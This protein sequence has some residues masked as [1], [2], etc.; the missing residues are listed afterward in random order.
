MF[1][2]KETKHLNT[3]K[4]MKL[5][6]F[7]D[8]E[9][10]NQTGYPAIGLEYYAF[11]RGPVPKKFW[12]EIKDGVAPDDLKDKVVL[13]LKTGEY[14][15]N[16]KEIEFIA[17]PKAQVNFSIFTPREKKILEKLAFIYEDANAKMMS[18][19]SHEAEWPWEI[20]KNEKGINSEID[21][22][23]ALKKDSTI[24]RE[25]AEENLRDHFSILRVFDI[26]PVK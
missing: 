7:F 6:N 3:T 20:T 12:L 22:L 23:L 5:L 10:F 14:D 8:F 9:H 11:E 1:F 18:E 4:L 17:K 16:R 15:Q 24:N 25:E 19:I 2:A 21:Y 26:E 13:N